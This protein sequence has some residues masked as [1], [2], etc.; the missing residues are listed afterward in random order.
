MK[1]LLMAVVIFVT[2]ISFAIAAEEQKKVSSVFEN[3]P[4]GSYQE[5]SIEEAKNIRAPMFPPE[6]CKTPEE[7]RKELLYRAARQGQVSSIQINPTV[8]IKNHR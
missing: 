8:L 3:L 1:A 2:S 5:L 4:N 6:G 7:T